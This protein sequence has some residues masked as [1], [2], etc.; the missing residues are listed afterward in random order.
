M[1]QLYWRKNDDLFV[2]PDEIYETVF[3]TQASF[4]ERISGVDRKKI[5]DDLLDPRKALQQAE[6]L[7]EFIPLQR[8]AKVME[9]GTGF[10]VN[11]GVWIRRFG[12]DGYG[13]EPSDEEFDGT[14]PLARRLFSINSIEPNRLLNGLGESLPFRDNSF[15]IVFSTNVLEHTQIPEQVIMEAVR[16]LKPDGVLQVIYPNYHSFFEGHYAIFHPP[17][18]ARWFLPW[19]IRIITGRDASFAKTLRTE[20]NPSWTKR[21]IKK[22][23]KH[24][25][26]KVLTLGEELFRQRMNNLNFQEWAGLVRVK[27]IVS[28]IRGMK[29]QYLI[30]SGMIGMNLWTPIVLT[31]KKG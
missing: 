29:L 4:I 10:G 6:V 25:T 5:T 26:L 3:S 21:V 19:Y 12:V 31:L 11:L 28:H 14:L 7:Q 17:V 8:G 18:F 2:I 15:D 23:R 20:L 24:T 22:L 27:N 30:S 1:N 13:V 9:I 16:V